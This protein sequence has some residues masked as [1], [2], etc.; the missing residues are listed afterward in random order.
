VPH[1]GVCT[2]V[3]IRAFRKL[4]V[5]LQVEVHKDMKAAFSAYP[6]LWGMRRPDPNIDHR[7]VPNLMRYFERRGRA[8]RISLHARDYLPGDIVAWDLGGG[9]PH[10]GI[11]SDDF[12]PS[13][14][15]RLILHNIG[16][17]VTLE[18]VLFRFKITG[19]YRYD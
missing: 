6:Q 17:G 9:V 15:R 16:G 3:L 5:D 12:D 2:D 10:I 13:T 4:G 8:V 1:S 18:D 14:T 7:R 19:H 11:V